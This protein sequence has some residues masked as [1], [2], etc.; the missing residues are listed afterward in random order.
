MNVGEV[1]YRLQH[2]S[3]LHNLLYAYLEIRA[4]LSIGPEEL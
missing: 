2:I 3:T 4:T 1:N